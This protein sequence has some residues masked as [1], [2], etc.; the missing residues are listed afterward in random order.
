MSPV[1]DGLWPVLSLWLDVADGLSAV[2]PQTGADL[3]DHREIDLGIVGT[4]GKQHR[5]LTAH[6]CAFA[7]AGSAT[8]HRQAPTAVPICASM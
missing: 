6:V 3:P 7:T 4:N 8:A 2:N 5:C 1:P